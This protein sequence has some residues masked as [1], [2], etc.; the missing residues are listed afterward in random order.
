MQ[1]LEGV[2]TAHPTEVPGEVGERRIELGG[3]G[4]APLLG[5]ATAKSHQLSALRGPRGLLVPCRHHR[6][7]RRGGEDRQQGEG[8]RRERTVFPPSHSCPLNLCRTGLEPRGPSLRPG[9]TLLVC[10]AEWRPGGDERQ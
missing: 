5:A 3:P 2:V 7:S 10:R 6:V 8:A 9:H 4:A 1:V